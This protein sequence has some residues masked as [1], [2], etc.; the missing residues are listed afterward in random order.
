MKK[1]RCAK[2][3]IQPVFPQR[4]VFPFAFSPAS[5]GLVDRNGWEEERCK[6]RFAWHCSWGKQDENCSLMGSCVRIRRLFNISMSSRRVKIDGFCHCLSFNNYW[7]RLSKISWLIC[8]WR[9]RGVL[10]YV[11]YTET[12]R[13]TGFLA[14]LSWAG[15]I[16]SCESV[17]NRVWTCPQISM[18]FV[19]PN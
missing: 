6:H 14:S 1:T 13:W 19:S 11:A 15:Y 17:L 8:Q 10:P 16:I 5:C 3:T 12:C 2:L 7:T 4:A 9:A 18:G